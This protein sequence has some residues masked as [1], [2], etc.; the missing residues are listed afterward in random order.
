M[1]YTDPDTPA[2]PASSAWGCRGLTKR[3]YFAVHIAAGLSADPTITGG[4]GVRGSCQHDGCV[5]C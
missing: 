3:E 4:G 2:T 5:N 1:R